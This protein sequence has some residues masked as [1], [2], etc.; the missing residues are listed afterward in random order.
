MVL[1]CV[2]ASIMM[3]VLLSMRRPVAQA[4][5]GEPLSPAVADASVSRPVPATTDTSAAQR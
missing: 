2:L 5:P 1:A 3:T 4:V